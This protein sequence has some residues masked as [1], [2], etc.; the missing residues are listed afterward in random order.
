MRNNFD[1]ASQYHLKAVLSTGFLYLLRTGAE[2]KVKRCRQ[3][4][5]SIIPTQERLFI[6]QE[7]KGNPVRVDCRSQQW[8]RFSFQLYLT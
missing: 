4:N 6:Q 1:M 8:V 7:W 3:G 2:D 5:E